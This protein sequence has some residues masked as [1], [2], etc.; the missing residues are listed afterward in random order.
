MQK[1][2]DR[3]TVKQSNFRIDAEWSAAID[4]IQSEMSLRNRTDAMRYAA[5]TEAKRLK[6]KQ[7]SNP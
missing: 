1:Q 7:R 4:F 2:T 5:I 6:E 3:H